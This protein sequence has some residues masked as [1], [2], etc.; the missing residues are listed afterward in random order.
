MDFGIIIQ[1]QHLQK[2]FNDITLA[3]MQLRRYKYFIMVSFVLL[4]GVFFSALSSLSVK[5][6]LVRLTY[7]TKWGE[8]QALTKLLVLGMEPTDVVKILGEPT[9]KNHFAVGERWVYLEDH[10]ASDWTYIAE[11]RYRKGSTNALELCYI[12]NMK[13]RILPGAPR[14]EIGKM[15]EFNE[16]GGTILFGDPTYIDQPTN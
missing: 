11:F 15:L 3:K 2:R 16:K 7:P 4:V 8:Y 6:N 5:C 9:V 12:L 1:L 13:D 14:C 10:S